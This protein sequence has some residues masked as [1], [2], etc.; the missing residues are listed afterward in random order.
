MSKLAESLASGSITGSIP[1]RW[2]SIAPLK[3]GWVYRLSR[4]AAQKRFP[5][6]VFISPLCAIMR[7]GCDSAQAGNVFVEK[8]ECTSAT[9]VFIA[10]SVNSG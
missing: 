9:A 8:R 1:A 10:P 4:A 2:R 7:K 6:T 3:R 5:F